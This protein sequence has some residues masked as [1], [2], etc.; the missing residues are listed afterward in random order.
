MTAVRYED[1]LAGEE[2]IA[3][4]IID[5]DVESVMCVGISY[6]TAPLA[7]RE[8]LALAPASV[9]A[10]L[11]RFGCGQ[12]ERPAD[13]SELVILSTCNRLEFYAAAGDR[14]EQTLLGIIAQSTSVDFSEL[15]PAAYTLTG[16]AAVRHLCRTAAGLESMI[17]GESQILGQ[18]S[19]AYS[20]ALAQGAAGHTLS[21]LFRG[22][23]RAGRRA[24]AETSINRNPATVSSVAVKLVSE[25]VSD[26]GAARVLLVGAGEMA[27]L[28]LSALH[29]RGA[30]D[31][32]VVSRTREHAERL[33]GRFAI[34][35]LPFDRLNA[36]LESADVVITSTSAPHH[37]IT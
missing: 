29:H 3:Q 25:T 23:L 31:V 14:G 10:I 9:A 5:A 26:L 6:R 22:A 2:T 21:T 18:I 16:A 35:S 17:L 30:R 11:S 36:A 37:V 4:P 12:T 13:V 33:S 20:A 19:D 34:R 27:E 15:E 28:A 8:R 24:R 1:A 7:L 32:C